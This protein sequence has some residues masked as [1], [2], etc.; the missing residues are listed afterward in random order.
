MLGYQSN[1]HE[2][3]V[4]VSDK[5]PASGAGCFPAPPVGWD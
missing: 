2:G 3:F 5:K 4:R 1:V